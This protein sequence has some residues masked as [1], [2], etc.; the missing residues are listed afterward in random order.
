MHD[1]IAVTGKEGERERERGNREKMPMMKKMTK[2]GQMA[3]CACLYRTYVFQKC[4]TFGTAVVVGGVG[5]VG[6]RFAYTASIDH[7]SAG[8]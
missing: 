6:G 3:G 1:A 7:R 2:R 4:T 5:G 8:R